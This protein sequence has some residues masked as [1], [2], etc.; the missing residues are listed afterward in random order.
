[1]YLIIFSEAVEYINQTIPVENRR[2]K[3]KAWD[4]K[5]KGKNK[6]AALKEISIV[7]QVCFTKV[8]FLIYLISFCLFT[9]KSLEN[10]SYKN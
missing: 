3:Y 6:Q 10:F 4:F 9:F 5:A 7:C 1:M 8:F 2:I